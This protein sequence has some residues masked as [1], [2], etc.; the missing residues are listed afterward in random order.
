M[1]RDWKE[2][3]ED[4]ILSYD[5]ANT[6]AMAQYERI[7]SRKFRDQLSQLG[8]SVCGSANAISK[9]LSQVRNVTRDSIDELNKRLDKMIES[10]N[11]MQEM[12]RRYSIVMAC[13]TGAIALSAIIQII[14]AVINK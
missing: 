10:S 2:I 7:M 11:N 14:I 13:L 5:E 9:T 8:V 4:S 6:G 1:P 12:T 3:D